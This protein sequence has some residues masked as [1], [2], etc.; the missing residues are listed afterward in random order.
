MS[1]LSYVSPYDPPIK[2]KMIGALERISGRRRIQAR[3]DELQAM[4]L[5]PAEI[6]SKA[7]ELLE[8]EMVF[9]AEQLLKIPAGGPLVFVANHPFGVVDGLILGHLVSQVREKFVVLVN[10]VLCRQDERLNRFL[11]PID[12]Q[13]SKA[14]IRTNLQTRQIAT[15]RLS[16]GEAMAIFPSGAV[17]TSPK[18]FGKAEEL[19]WKRFTAKVIQLS[20][21][22][23]VPVFFHGQ[24]S[25]LFQLASQVSVSL[26]LGMLLHEACN[27]MGKEVHLNIGDPIPYAE[28]APFKDR[29][30]LLDHLRERTFALA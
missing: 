12:F 11:L 15:Q 29:Q 3:Y 2:Q 21:A 17:A 22:T 8:V 16:D 7:L 6:W 13:E 1:Q 25:R 24:N 23:V 18:G 20:Q 19:E 26:R 4:D 9:P 5:K 14:A 27:K 10:E 28:L 30:V